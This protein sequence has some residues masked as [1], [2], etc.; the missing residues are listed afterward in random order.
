MTTTTWCACSELAEEPFRN[1]VITFE[2]TPRLV[3]IVGDTLLKRVSCI[4][5]I[6]WGGSTNFQA[7]LDLI[8]DK[9]H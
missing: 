2:E 7:A 1:L 6:P 8:L 9:V 5:G 4:R 3:T